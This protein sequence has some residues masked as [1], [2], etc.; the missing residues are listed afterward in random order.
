MSAVLSAGPSG[1]SLQC[2]VLCY[3]ACSLSTHDVTIIN[4][5]SLFNFTGPIES[6]GADTDG[7]F[8]WMTV[9]FKIVWH[10]G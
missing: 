5:V 2:R 4:E 1:F 6:E 9:L 3:T 8:L 10:D 7:R